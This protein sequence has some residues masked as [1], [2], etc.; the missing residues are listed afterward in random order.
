MQSKYVWMNGEL[1]EYQHATLH[2]LTPALHYTTVSGHS[3]E[4]AA[5]RPSAVRRYSAS[6]STWS[7]W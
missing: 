7:G 6:A 2:F 4:Y 1:V 5:M 3:R